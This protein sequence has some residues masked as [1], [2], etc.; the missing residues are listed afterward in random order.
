MRTNFSI[1]FL[2]YTG[3]TA[4]AFLMVWVFRRALHVNQT[5]VA[6]SFLV[7]VMAAASRW[8][9]VYSVYLSLLCTLLYNY[10]FLPP[11]GR[12]TIA[13]PENWVTLTAF[14]GSGMLVSH[15]SDKA[16]RQAEAS[17]TRRLEVE[18]LYE[19]SQ[20]LLLIDL[21]GLASAAPSLVARI[22]SLRAVALYVDA[23]D[24]AYYSDPEN[25]LLP[26]AEL[27]SMA[28]NGSVDEMNAV[29][30]VPLMLGMRR[31]GLLAIAGSE[32]APEM[33]S[34]IGG[35]VAIAL[36][37]ASVLEQSGHLKAAQESERLRAALMDSI[38]HELRTPL[39]S[40]RAAATSLISQP[41]LPEA[42]RAEMYAVVEEETRRLDGLVGQAVRMAQ[43]DTENV[44]VK[45]Q[46][47]QLRQLIDAVLSDAEEQ[48][49]GREV[50]LQL[51]PEMPAVNIDGELFRQVLRHLVENAVKYSPAGAPLKISATIEQ[52]RLVLHV[53]D[54]G[55]GIRD[56]DRPFIFD[57]F[58][59]G[60]RE[61]ERTPGTGMGLAII[62][63]ILH[64][65][66]GGIDFISHEGRGADFAFWL[67]LDD[68]RSND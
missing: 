12:L 61:R 51:Q 65:Q 40:I 35:L 18:Q 26:V 55:R 36:E 28:K 19:F 52:E 31:L 20:Q 58:Y 44:R 50:N 33:A 4:L 7:L 13:D 6:L 41:D 29:R 27:R 53:L 1:V 39:T 68:A 59:R 47:Q 43:L 62:R 5:T 67:P 60:V 38:T 3:S 22:F 42:V 57:K 9:L 15:L 2:R 25:E 21:P 64:A 23:Q 32:C 34:A 16:R 11:V 45:R 66:G 54:H 30:V 48:L 10:Y 17:E 49:R 63:A 24:E 56:E 14:L 8:R 37:R 46:R